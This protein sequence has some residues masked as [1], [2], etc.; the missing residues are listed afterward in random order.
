MV[1]CL[2]LLPINPTQMSSHKAECR[3]NITSF[4]EAGSGTSPYS[5]YGPF[6]YEPAIATCLSQRVRRPIAYYFH[7]YHFYQSLLFL[8]VSGEN[9]PDPQIYIQRQPIHFQ[10][11][12][13]SCRGFNNVIQQFQA[14]SPLSSAGWTIRQSCLDRTSQLT[15]GTGGNRKMFA[16]FGSHLHT[17]TSRP[18]NDQL[19]S[20]G[21]FLMSTTNKGISS[22]LW[23]GRCLLNA[24][25]LTNVAL[26][27]F[28]RFP[29]ASLWTECRL[30]ASWSLKD[31]NAGGCLNYSDSFFTNPQVRVLW[32]SYM[33]FLMA[34]TISFY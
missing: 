16:S 8:P 28:A 34:A 32:N 14:S 10:R 1:T 21:I 18:T 23:P 5:G 22:R 24:S 25:E 11:T 26:G 19:P 29:W 3:D 4:T 15:R 31:G 30:H 12:Y 17:L 13:S 33:P 27:Q 2:R 20:V 6:R 7:N 9:R